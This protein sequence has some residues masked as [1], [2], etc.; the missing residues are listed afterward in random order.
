MHT[1][2]LVGTAMKKRYVRCTRHVEYMNET[3][4]YDRICSERKENNTEETLLKM[5]V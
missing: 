4:M 3:K 1:E 5:G 2:F